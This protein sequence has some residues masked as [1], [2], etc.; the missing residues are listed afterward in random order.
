MKLHI[1][2]EAC[3]GCGLCVGSYPDAFAFDDNGKATVVGDIDETSAEEA[4]AS[5]P[6]G[7][8]SK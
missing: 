3:V 1:D 4:I 6:A 8:I 5:C 2:S 7:A